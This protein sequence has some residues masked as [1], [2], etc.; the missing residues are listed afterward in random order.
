MVKRL[1]EPVFVELLRAG[2]EQGDAVGRMLE[3]FRDRHIGQ[4]LEFIHLD[5]AR[6]WT[7]QG[8]AREVGMSRSAFAER[9]RA[10]IGT[11]PMGYLA[12][13]RLE[14]ARSLLEKTDHAIQQIAAT[15]GYQS[16]ASFTRAFVSKFGATPSEMRRAALA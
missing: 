10:M 9:F 13:W 12:D 14:Q 11:G 3:A 6:A 16:A 15:V 8:L 4:A 5:P 7:V 1:S 2:K